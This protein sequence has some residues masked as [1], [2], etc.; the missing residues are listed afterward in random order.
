[1]TAVSSIWTA[2]SGYSFGTFPEG[3][4]FS[5]A[6]PVSGDTGVAYQVIS[7]K[8]PGGLFVKRNP[9]TNIAEISGTPYEVVRDTTYTFCIRASLNGSISDR[10]FSITIQNTDGPTFIYPSGRLPL[11][12][13]NQL[14][15][16]SLD[17]V[18]FQVEVNDPN[19]SAGANLTYA[20]LENG[21]ELPPGLMLTN[22]GRIVGFVQPTLVISLTDGSGT[23]DEGLYD[24]VAY[25]FAL[26][27]T[28]GYDSYFYD[29]VFYDYSLP[30]KNPKQLNTNYQFKITVSDGNVSA[31]RTYSIFVVGD[32]Y[33]Q[34]DNTQLDDSSTVI[35]ADTSFVLAPVWLT[36]ANLGLHRANNYL[37]IPLNTYDRELVTFNSEAVNADIIVT[38][39]KIDSGDNLLGGTTV[40]VFT[41]NGVP[42][43]GQYF[44]LDNR[45]GGVTSRVYKII[46]VQS[47]DGNLYRLTIDQSLEITIPQD[48]V[49]IVGGLADDLS[50]IGLSYDS[51]DSI[52]YG[53][54][55]YQPAVTQTYTFTISA[56]R[57]GFNQET[58]FTARK[59]T[60]Q[61]IGDV[62]SVIKWT[63]PNDLGIINSGYI[64]NLFVEAS[65]TIPNAAVVYNLSSGNLP[66]GLSMDL[67]GEIIGKVKQFGRTV[68][69]GG[70]PTIFDHNTTSFDT[71]TTIFGGSTSITAL[72]SGNGSP[73]LFDH[74]AATFDHRL[75]IFDR[76]YQ[77]GETSFYDIVNHTKKYMTFDSKTSTFDQ[78]F[79]FTVTAR[80][81]FG[82]SATSK[83]FKIRVVPLDTTSYSNIRVQPYLSSVQRNSFSEFIN[84]NTVFTPNNIY[85][86]ADPNFGIQKTLSMIIYAGIETTAAGAYIGAMGLNHKRKQFY[87]GDIKTAIAYNPGTTD[88]LYEV[89]YVQ[90]IDPLEYNGSY[91]PHEIKDQRSQTEI[92]SADNS[93]IDQSLTVFNQSIT[94]DGQA[95]QISNPRANNYFPSSVSIWRDRISAI[96][97]TERDYLPLWMRSIQPGTKQ[98]LNFQLAIPLCFCKVG[99]SASIV[100]NIKNYLATTDFDFKNINYTVDRYI[101]DS[102]KDLAGDKYLVFRNDRITL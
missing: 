20:I 99:T 60:I 83:T 36:P 16:A 75:T 41:T 61:I 38:S 24:A 9:I 43:A 76:L 12:P 101:I 68:F 42:S 56:T 8:L 69:A 67:S 27:P 22:T 45:I 7:G 78:V 96:G 97:A 58:A 98:E 88:A 81:Q 79:T 49:F 50:R 59:F 34:A 73:T 71:A 19:I 66:P 87:F 6:L 4:I 17:Y 35:T 72:P 62:E 70:N 100:L 80:D 18:D 63:T 85:R 48:L 5:Q 21:G 74:G 29:N 95:Y 31:S 82:Y 26:V 23:Y 65:T 2:Q 13:N 40:G 37:T 33:F 57:L 54:V 25:D 93:I 94:V 51:G 102:I 3:I 32:S 53:Q 77:P 39:Q 28:N 52:L 91:L 11:G 1:M 47:Y 90:M 44:T 46:S 84:N 14:F 89:V 55:P 15:V 10:T 64:S 86:P 92:L 30:S